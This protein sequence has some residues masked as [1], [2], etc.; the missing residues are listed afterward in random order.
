LVL[1]LIKAIEAVKF[2][3]GARVIILKSTTP[4]IFCAGADLKVKATE[5]LA[6]D[7]T[8]GNCSIK[9]GWLTYIF[10]FLFFF[11]CEN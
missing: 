1:E 9:A 7:S 6:W 2:D 8:D 5:H 11:L 3:T 4:G 10:L